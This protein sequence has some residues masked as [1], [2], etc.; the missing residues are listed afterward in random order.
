RAGWSVDLDMEGDLDFVLA[1]DGGAPIVL[2]NRGDGSFE[3]RDLFGDVTDV[4]DFA[5]ADLDADGDPDAAFVTG[6]GA[7][8][9]YENRR[10]Q[11]FHARR[12]AAVDDAVAL[13]I[14]DLGADEIGRAAWKDG[15][16]Q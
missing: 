10:S 5:W 9:V 12:M 14:A 3:Q 15:V 11:G 4:V 16:T 13:T 7:V 1:R 6:S 2:R 8:E